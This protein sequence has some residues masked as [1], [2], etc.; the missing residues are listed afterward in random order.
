MYKLFVK[1]LKQFSYIGVN[2]EEK[3]RGQ[4]F[5]LDITLY[6]EDNN[7]ALN[8]DSVK[9]TTSYAEVVKL[10]KAVMSNCRYNLIEFTAKEIAEKILLNFSDVVR[11]GVCLKKPCAPMNARFDYV[12]TYIERERAT[13]DDG[14]SHRARK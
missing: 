8:T 14:S 13:N 4:W 7:L 12:G 3:D 11:V 9:D 10:A 2:S 1:G 5:E 6:L